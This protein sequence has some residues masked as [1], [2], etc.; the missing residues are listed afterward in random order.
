MQRR[1][2]DYAETID[3]TSGS[4]ILK[5]V[6]DKDGFELSLALGTK[7]DADRK[8]TLTSGKE[9]WFHDAG[10]IRLNPKRAKLVV[11]DGLRNPCVRVDDGRADDDPTSC[12]GKFDDCA[13][14]DGGS[15][16]ANALPD[17]PVEVRARHR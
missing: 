3:T 11:L 7:L 1:Y 4:P 14:H 12:F 6:W 10:Q 16:L 15:T 9:E 13:P 2:E 8:I 17:K 5:A